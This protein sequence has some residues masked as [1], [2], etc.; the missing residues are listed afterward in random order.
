MIQ[1]KREIPDIKYVRNFFKTWFL[2]HGFSKTNHRDMFFKDQGFYLICAVIE[3]IHDMGL[4][5]TLIVH[6]LWM[7]ENILHTTIIWSKVEYSDRK[8]L[9]VQ[10]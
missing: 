10:V 3:P 8:S 5:L 9:K 7:I 6:F 1:E 4:F 2:S